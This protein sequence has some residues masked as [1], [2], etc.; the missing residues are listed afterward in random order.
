VSDGESQG[1]RGAALSRKRVAD[2]EGLGAATLKLVR[3]QA[4]YVLP[5]AC[6]LAILADPL[7]DVLFS[8]KWVEAAAVLTPIA[9][10]TAVSSVSFPLGDMLK[11][12]GR[13]RILVVFHLVEL[14]L[15]VAVIVLAAP[16]G[17]VTVAWARA[18]SVAVFGVA[19]V[20][21]ARPWLGT[22]G[23]KVAEAAGPGVAM[24]LGVALGA[25]AVRLLWDDLGPLPLLAG[26]AAGTIGA[27]VLVRVAAPATA[28]EVWDQLAPILRRRTAAA[29]A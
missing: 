12:V 15:L 18:A 8:D 10:M 13:Q 28:R 5:V 26:I 17:I 11:A 21:A 4:L 24:A 7:V 14:P 29:S 20:I 1:V 6:G 16:S 22:G 25:G 9:V 27:L 2:R 19:H 23:M 3:Y